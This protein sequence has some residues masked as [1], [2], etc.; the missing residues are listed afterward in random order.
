MKL[1]Y[2]YHEKY[3]EDFGVYAVKSSDELMEILAKEE[4]KEVTYVRQNYIY[5]EM[6]QYINERTGKKYKVVLE[7]V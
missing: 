2:A 3:I 4:N 7:E 5:G 6:T 1:F